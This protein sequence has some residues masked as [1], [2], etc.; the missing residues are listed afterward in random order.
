MPSRSS[1]AT[2]PSS[3]PA[4]RSWCR[5]R[6]RIP[7]TAMVLRPLW[8]CE[9]L[10][11]APDQYLLE[12]PRGWA[13]YLLRCRSRDGRWASSCCDW[14]W[15]EQR[16]PP[17]FLIE[18][19]YVESGFLS[20]AALADFERAVGCT[21]ARRSLKGRAGISRGCREAAGRVDQA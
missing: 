19:G 3:T 13:Q 1:P 5:C 4:V 9:A 10:H 20:D 12:R 16:S 11:C 18:G 6:Y 7:L 15:K 21:D 2:R 17:R 14:N 8:L